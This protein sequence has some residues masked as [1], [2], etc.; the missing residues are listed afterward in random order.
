M[1]AY[2]I[3]QRGNTQPWFSFEVSCVIWFLIEYVVRFITSPS[4]WKFIV[5]FL[6]IIDLLAIA[7]YFIVV[8]INTTNNATPLSVL[9]VVRLVRLF[10]IFK[11]SRHSMSLQILGNTLKASMRE[12]MMLIFFL[13]LGV[14]AFSTTIWW[15]EDG[16]STFSSIP[17]AFW[18][19]LVTMTTVGY[20][21]VTP[22]TVFGKLIGS[23]CTLTGVL[24]LAM[25]VPVIVSNFEYFYKR[26][27]VI[28]GKGKDRDAA[29]KIN[30]PFIRTLPVK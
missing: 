7:P 21:D 6:N 27:Q 22:K 11:L 10:R 4:K 3:D 29:P 16:K 15:A 8:A 26:D 12:L 25:P 20:G 1:L 17:D 9:R 28:S 2:S 13:C 24:T 19:S 18:F 5:S 23:L 30:P 14:L